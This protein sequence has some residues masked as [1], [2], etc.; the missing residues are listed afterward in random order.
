[1]SIYYI[2]SNKSDKCYVKYTKCHDL[3]VILNKYK[4]QFNR[5]TLNNAILLEI[6]Q[7]DDAEIYIISC[8]PSGWCRL[9][10][11]NKVKEEKTRLLHRLTT[12]ESIPTIDTSNLQLL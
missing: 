6:L 9:G 1:M 3:R 8:I 12:K 4:S 11:N 7:H 2:T 5:G 10:I